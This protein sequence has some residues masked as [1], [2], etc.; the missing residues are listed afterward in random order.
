MAT[1]S[2]ILAWRSPWT[3]E[4]GRLQYKV[5]ESDM[6]E[7]LDMQTFK[8][9]KTDQSQLSLPRGDT[10]RRRTPSSQNEGSHRNQSSQHLDLGLSSHQNCEKKMSVV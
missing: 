9:R 2:T 8:K 5:A 1:H 3:E 4:T 7:Q 10:M 6:T